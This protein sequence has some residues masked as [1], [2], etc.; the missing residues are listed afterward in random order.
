M[1]NELS[2]K[3]NEILS[4]MRK[5]DHFVVDVGKTM[6]MSAVP[7]LLVDKWA[8][9]L[10]E[11]L[12]RQY[13]INLNNYIDVQKKI[14]EEVHKCTMETMS[15]IISVSSEINALAKKIESLSRIDE[16][17]KERVEIAASTEK[18]CNEESTK[19]CEEE[20]T[21][22]CGCDFEY[23]FKVLKEDNILAND[24]ATVVN[25]RIEDLRVEM[26]EESGATHDWGEHLNWWSEGGKHEL[27]EEGTPEFDE[28]KKAFLQH[29]EESEKVLRKLSE[30]ISWLKEVIKELGVDEP[31][32]NIKPNE[33]NVVDRLL[34]AISKFNVK[35]SDVPKDNESTETNYAAEMK[36]IREFFRQA[37]IVAKT[38]LSFGP[39]VKYN[40]QPIMRTQFCEK[41]GCDKCLL[42]EKIPP[43]E[44][45]D[46]TKNQCRERVMEF[47]HKNFGRLF[48]DEPHN[49]ESDSLK[50]LDMGGKSETS[51]QSDSEPNAHRVGLL[52]GE[53]VDWDG[54]KSK[55]VSWVKDFSYKDGMIPTP[56][57]HATAE[58]L[59]A[60]YR[61]NHM[62][63]ELVRSGA[64][65]SPEQLPNDTIEKIEK[66]KKYLTDAPHQ[67]PCPRN[68]DI[69]KDALDAKHKIVA[70]GGEKW[71]LLSVLNW[72]LEPA[73]YSILPVKRKEGES[74]SAFCSRPAVTD[75]LSAENKPVRSC[76]H[77]SVGD[78]ILCKT[79]AK[80]ICTNWR[81]SPEDV[82][83]T[84]K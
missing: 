78:C 37:E 39:M 31:C 23:M 77:C 73:I 82:V 75:E 74:T 71:D 15:Q 51:F 70:L 60:L 76:E 9:E 2:D 56:Y 27:P 47:V 14:K 69:V 18:L 16:P 11:E 55:P 32:E 79:T 57:Y 22:D 34:E 83:F 72:M 54:F 45:V 5:G 66:L 12:V 33:H 61:V 28:M 62:A 40:W 30:E 8:D 6:Q 44:S 59:D 19:D 13:G 80:V 63:S 67:P 50:D 10:E 1:K 20:S 52:D 48:L 41:V 36:R 68:C 26:A 49:E 58:I 7:Q 81:E 38:N 42:K 64:F 3:T 24:I 53:I 25:K 84:G 21:K 4:E 17:M 46:F 65:K 35:L 43:F 29:H